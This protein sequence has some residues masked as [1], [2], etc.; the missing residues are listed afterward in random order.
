MVN[1]SLNSPST[2]LHPQTLPQLQTHSVSL[3]LLL[4]RRPIL[5]ITPSIPAVHNHSLL[6]PVLLS[7]LA[8][9][10]LSSFHFTLSSGRWSP[11]WLTSA[12]T[13]Q[14][15]AGAASGIEVVGWLQRS[16]FE[17][18]AEE[19][20]RWID[21]TSAL[22]G[23]FCAGI[24]GNTRGRAES[25]PEW[26][27]KF[28]GIDG[29]RDGL[30]LPSCFHTFLGPLTK[31][32]FPHRRTLAIQNSASKIVGNLHGVSDAFHIFTAMWSSCWSGKLVEP[33]YFV[34]WRLDFDWGACSKTRR[35]RG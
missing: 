21:F 16:L 26:A 7:L 9:Y 20:K 25:R 5:L 2:Y 3:S 30:Y 28:D 18:D 12:E 19:E 10:N 27:Y 22:G 31:Q 34:R 6:P 23:L 14:S 15:P 1:Y 29:N 33:P 11:I 32:T 24:I 35:R 8:I 17:T 4:S 13:A